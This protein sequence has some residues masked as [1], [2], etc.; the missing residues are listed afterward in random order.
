ME[1]YSINNTRVRNLDQA[2]SLIREDSQDVVTILAIDENS[3]I[4]VL[5]EDPRLALV[6]T[7]STR[8]TDVDD[9]EYR[10]ILQGRVSVKEASTVEDARQILQPRPPAGRLPGGVLGHTRIC[11][12]DNIGECGTRGAS[13]W[14]WCMLALANAL[15]PRR[16]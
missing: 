16:S 6:G 13:L 3:R 2:V 11:W 7:E 4:K 5:T 12:K 1:V 10:Q 15:L 14:G 8:S 9:D